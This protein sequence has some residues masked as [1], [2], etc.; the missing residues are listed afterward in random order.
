M[1]DAILVGEAHG[2]A[3]AHREHLRQELQVALIHHRLPR[4]GTCAVGP[5]LEPDHHVGMRAAVDARDT[6][7]RDDTRRGGG[8]G[9]RARDEQGD[10]EGPHTVSASP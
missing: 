5:L 10:E 9:E 8:R 3:H 7:E 4:V 6:A 2:G 1:E